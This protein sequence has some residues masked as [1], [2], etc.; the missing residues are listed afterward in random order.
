MIDL[1]PL[2]LSQIVTWVREQCPVA[3]ARYGDGEMQC[4]MGVGISETTS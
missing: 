1:H 3:F 4:V 2:P